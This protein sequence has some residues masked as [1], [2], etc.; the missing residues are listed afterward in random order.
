M[1]HVLLRFENVVRL[2]AI[3]E[4]TETI[5]G[6][7]CRDEHGQFTSCEIGGRSMVAQHASEKSGVP[8][9]RFD[10]EDQ[11]AAQTA[12]EKKTVEVLKAEHFDWA[13]SDLNAMRDLVD[14]VGQRGGKMD[15]CLINPPLCDDS[16][17]IERK[18]MPQFPKEQTDAFIAALKAD[19]VAIT[20]DRVAVE[21]LKA[22]QGEINAVKVVGMATAMAGGKKIGGGDVF[23]SADN[24]VLDGH[25]RWAAMWL[26]DQ[27]A[28]VEITRIDLPIRKLL[29]VADK[30]SA[31]KKTFYELAADAF[32]RAALVALSL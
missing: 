5:A 20:P 3:D 31:K 28:K 8:D 13:K 9:Q 7:L 2:R 14:K 21:D 17:D 32:E 1:N 10:A 16:L 25:H 19:G 30:F 4:A 29:Q 26:N 22:T 18:D 15:L 23:V 12:S 6:N 27:H 24:Y 11:K